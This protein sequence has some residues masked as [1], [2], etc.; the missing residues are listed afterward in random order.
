MVTCLSGEKERNKRIY[1]ELDP[2]TARELKKRCVDYNL[3]M[4]KVIKPSVEEFLRNN[5][6][7]ID[8]KPN[9]D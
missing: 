4:S 3:T 2:H 7:K 1:I 5:P 8:K 9:I 6:P